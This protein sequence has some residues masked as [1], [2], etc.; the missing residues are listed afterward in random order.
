MERLTV[1]GRPVVCPGCK[2]EFDFG[3]G[4]SLKSVPVIP[5]QI[6]VCYNCLVVSYFNDDLILVT[7]TGD[8]RTSMSL[9]NQNALIALVQ[10]IKE[11]RERI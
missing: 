5:G 4:S 10:K 9:K 3:I 11:R 8:E 7:M 6:S 1:K 2:C